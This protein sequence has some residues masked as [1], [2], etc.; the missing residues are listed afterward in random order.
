MVSVF[1]CA[2]GHTWKAAAHGAAGLCPIC[3][4]T[5]AKKFYVCGN[6]GKGLSP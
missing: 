1:R 3:G 6:C 2:Q 5:N 4:T